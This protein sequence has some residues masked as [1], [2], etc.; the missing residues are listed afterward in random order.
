LKKQIG[1]NV[2][3]VASDLNWYRYSHN[4]RQCLHRSLRRL[5]NMYDIDILKTISTHL[6]VVCSWRTSVS[7]EENHSYFSSWSTVRKTI[8]YIN[9]SIYGDFIESLLKLNMQ[10]RKLHS[11]E[12]KFWFD[13]DRNFRKRDLISF[14]ITSSGVFLQFVR[15]QHEN[16]VK[17]GK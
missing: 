3:Y 8:N 17:N 1:E 9:Y 5:L 6:Y 4:D 15:S 11:K 16:A 14:C 12:K 13:I 10:V 7:Q 2:M